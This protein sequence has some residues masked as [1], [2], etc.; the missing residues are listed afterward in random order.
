MMAATS[1]SALG[2][3]TQGP[4]TRTLLIFSLPMLGANVL[5]SLNGS[6]NTI[7]IGRF[8]GEAALAATTNANIVMFLM[9][10][11]GFGFG[12]AATILV[13]Q[14]VGARD[15]VT[16]RRALGTGLGIFAVSSVLIAIFGW[17]SAGAI[18]HVLATPPESQA[19]ALAYLRV[20]FLGLP[21]M[22]LNVLIMTAL[23]GMGDPIT[24]LR[25]MILNVALD[26]GLN[27]VLILGLG[28]APRMGIAGA[29]T[30]T[31]IANYFALI[32]IVAYIYAKDIA[33]R[34][35]GPELRFLIPDQVLLKVITIKGLPMAA[36]M[37][38]MTLS[39]FVMIGLIN[40]EG[41]DVAA[42]YGV[43]QMLWTYV[44][45]PAAAIGAAVSAMAAQNIGAGAWHRIDPITRSGLL[46]SLLLTGGIVALL[47]LFDKPVLALFLGGSSPSIPIARHIQPIANGSFILLGATTIITSTVRA[48]GTVLMPTVILVTGVFGARLG[49]AWML[50]PY[51]RDALWWSFP[52]GSIVTLA[53]AMLYYRYG[54][55]RKSGLVAKIVHDQ[56]LM[57]PA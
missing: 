25:V 51:G 19:L 43:T 46:V 30:A 49:F 24:P 6:I 15:I 3:L 35:R 13:G 55:W 11:L 45:M 54:G 47:F 52:F 37:V 48:N 39:G 26:A 9:F 18:L 38:M 17:F 14:S 21:P 34:L 1:T 57:E 4:I 33:I 23:R 10:S 16:A 53:M 7:W 5:Q 50:L 32:A 36:Q 27:P 8:L 2:D 12:M 44:Q 29:A 28:P 22:F 42:G 56:P 31:L 41:V 40:R 20:I